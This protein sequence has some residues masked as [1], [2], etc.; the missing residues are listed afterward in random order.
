MTPQDYITLVGLCAGT[1]TTTAFL[2][3]VIRTWKTRSAKDISTGM[4]IMF[5]SGIALWTVYGFLIRSL[6]VIITNVTTFIL[7][8]IILVLKLRYK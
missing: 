1:L 2:P 5:C 7:A 8:S 4:F 6:P 3:Q